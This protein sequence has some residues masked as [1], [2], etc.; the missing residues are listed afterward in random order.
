M[1]KPISPKCA[2][3]SGRYA[4]ADRRADRRTLPGESVPASNFPTL[5]SIHGSVFEEQVVQYEAYKEVSSSYLICTLDAA[6]PPAAQVS[7]LKTHHCLMARSVYSER[8]NGS[9][10]ARIPFLTSPFRASRRQWLPR[11]ASRTSSGSRLPTR[12]SSASR[13]SWQPS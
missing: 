12:R 2:T 13:K 6:I 9:A 11:L 10:G 1:L 8:F 4:K 7:V 3:L 5:Q